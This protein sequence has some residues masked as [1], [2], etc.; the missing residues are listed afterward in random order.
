MFKHFK[1]K[2]IKFLIMKSIFRITFFALALL[3][4]QHLFAQKA[5]VADHKMTAKDVTVIHLTQTEGQFETQALNLRPG[6][7]IFEVT[8][9]GVDHEVA[10]MLTKAETPKQGIKEAGLPKMLKKGETQKS[11]VVELTTGTYLYNC[12]LNPTPQYTLTVE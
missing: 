2:T 3:G 9:D 11:G 6:K 12:P 7:Y 5:M 8:N 10:F 1:I 4:T